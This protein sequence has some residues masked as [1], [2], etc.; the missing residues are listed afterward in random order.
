MQYLIGTVFGETPVHTHRNYEIIYCAEG[1]GTVYT[2]G[3]KIPVSKGH[4]MIVPP[5]T[6][7][8][9]TCNGEFIRYYI[10][11]DL[12]RFFAVSRP[13]LLCDNARGDGLF[14]AEM[15]YKS[16][17]E[18]PAYVSALVNA[19]MHFLLQ[20]LQTDTEIAGII[21]SIV[22]VITDN[23]DDYALNLS[24]LLKKSGYAEDYIRAEFKKHTGKTPTRFLAETRIH[25]AS[26]L[27]DTYK[28]TLSLSEI[29]EK[30]GFTDYVYFS[31]RFKEIMG[32]SPK[33]YST[34]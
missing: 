19:Y 6:T 20:S 22:D 21:R 29:A 8:E 26:F 9:A 23:F 7:H 10:S 2:E 30:C 28:K 12:S 17:N 33:Q 5:G 32:Y 4:I 15:I 25:H 24:Q 34:L 1:R 11:G 3:R 13:T 16:R 31:R 18:S 27:I 14:L